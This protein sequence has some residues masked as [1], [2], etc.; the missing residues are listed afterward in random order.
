MKGLFII[1]GDVLSLID[2]F[3]SFLLLLSIVLTIPPVLLWIAAF[4][5]FAKGFVSFI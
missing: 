3:S 1:S 2:L 5:L 4:L